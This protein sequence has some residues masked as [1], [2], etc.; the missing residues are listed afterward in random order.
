MEGKEF[1]EEPQEQKKE[2][3]VELKQEEVMQGGGR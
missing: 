3:I 1:T 2:P